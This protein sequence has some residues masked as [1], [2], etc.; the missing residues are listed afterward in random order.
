[1]SS[2]FGCSQRLAGVIL[3]SLSQLG[4]SA[5]AGGEI[6]EKHRGLDENLGEGE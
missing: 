3:L 6:H 5:V 1:M 4:E 2:P